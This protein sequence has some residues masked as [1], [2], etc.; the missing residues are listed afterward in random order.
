VFVNL[1][2]LLN[3][4]QVSVDW[5]Y[6]AVPIIESIWDHRNMY[7]L[8]SFLGVASLGLTALSQHTR[9][10]KPLLFGLSLMVFPFLPASNLLFPVG[11]VV[12]E[13]VLY[14]PSMGYCLII[15]LGAWHILQRVS[16]YRRVATLFKV[17]IGCLLLT[18]VV[19]TVVRNR[20]WYSAT[21]LNRA[22]VQ[23]NPNNPILLSNLGI[24]HALNHNFPQAEWLYRSSMEQTPL[25]SGGYYNYAI[26]MKL[27]HRYEEA[28][29]VRQGAE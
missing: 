13:R 20:D 11:F 27:L 15:A 17:L 9:N 24:E 26:L 19:K 16:I 18:Y 3:P 10:T 14:L 25:Y 4:T 22:G 29:K 21:S 6:G 1:G 7:M 23:F 8:G 2:L 28:E 5:R 12:A